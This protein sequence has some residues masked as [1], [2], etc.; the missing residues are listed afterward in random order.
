MTAGIEIEAELVSEKTCMIA[1]SARALIVG[2]KN[3]C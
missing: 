1:A 3:A 2:V